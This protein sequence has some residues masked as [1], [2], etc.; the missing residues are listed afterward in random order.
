MTS[1]VEAI[2]P[3]FLL[4]VAG[5]AFKRRGFPGD[6]FWGPAERLSY[7]VL[8]PALIVNTLS[9]ADLAGI[10][11]G[12]LAAAVFA[13]ALASTVLA[14]LARP[15]LGVDGP[16]FTSVLQGMVRLNAYLGFAFAFTFHGTP[17]LAIAAMFVALMMPVANVISVAAL[18][19]FGAGGRASWSGVAI[20]IATNPLILACIAGVA[21]NPI[22]GMIPGWVTG[23]L[24]I[25]AQ[26]ALPL[27]L[28][29]VGAGLDFS[30]LKSRRWI[31]LATSAY[32]LAA[33][34]VIA[35]GIAEV[36]G[37]GGLGFVMVML[38]A[39]TP[40]SPSTYVLARQLGGDA[41]LMAG[42]VSAQTA[43]SVITMSVVL[44]LIGSPGA[45]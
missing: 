5:Y 45:T 40:A 36:L 20:G 41:G 8:L 31:I 28:L 1:V 32:K 12:K 24:G 6:G 38:F 3:I 29:C 19:V 33:L 10:Q 21:L 37:L 25:L 44:V 16:A 30:S 9:G 7:F 22:S 18:V 39:A 43:L 23:M 26:A 15:F 11:I 42:I 17:G 35:W 34:P 14:L 13:M 27:A 2:A 4:I